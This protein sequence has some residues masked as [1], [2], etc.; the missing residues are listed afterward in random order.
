MVNFSA[1]TNLSAPADE[2][3]NMVCYMFRALQMPIVCLLHI[4]FKYIIVSC[5]QH[6]T[7]VT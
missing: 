2:Q 5:I 6:R 1:T 4:Y 3:H 7:H